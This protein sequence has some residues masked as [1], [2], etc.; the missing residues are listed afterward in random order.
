LTTIAFFGVA[1]IIAAI[2]TPPLIGLPHLLRAFVSTSLTV[3]TLTYVVMP[4]LTRLFHRW[5]YP[6][7]A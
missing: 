7:Q 6:K 1:Q 5:L 2:A 3:L 4:R